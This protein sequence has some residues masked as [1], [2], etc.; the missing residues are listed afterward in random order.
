MSR[1]CR[2]KHRVIALLFA[3]LGIGAV[4]LTACSTVEG[5]GK[6]LEYLGE[7]MSG[8]SQDAQN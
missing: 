8:A 4:G 5:A 7:S 2:T 1:F 6:D 3:A